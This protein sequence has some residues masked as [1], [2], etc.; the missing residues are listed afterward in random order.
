[1]LSVA[2]N[3]YHW[4]NYLVLCSCSLMR[5][6][7]SEIKRIFWQG[8]RS[9][10]FSFYHLLFVCVIPLWADE[11]NY[12]ARM[13]SGNGA[14]LKS[15]KNLTCPGGVLN[16]RPHKWWYPCVL[17]TDC[18]SS[19]QLSHL[20]FDIDWWLSED[21]LCCINPS[22]VSMIKLLVEYE[23]VLICLCM[24]ICIYT[25]VYMTASMYVCA[26]VRIYDVYVSLYL[27]FARAF[28]IFLIELKLYFKINLKSNQWVG[29]ED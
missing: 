6:Q 23:F 22:V 27:Y 11:I 2:Y 15:P 26:Y 4:E 12:C 19:F 10:P 24:Y 28:I 18:Q 1:M 16:F 20:A 25:H 9:L 3:K 8:I 5:T 21:L 17:L 29:Q 14:H 7:P 13:W